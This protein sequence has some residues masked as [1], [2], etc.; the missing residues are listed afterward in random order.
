MIRKLESSSK[1]IFT[2]DLTTA[3]RIKLELSDALSEL[4]NINV[5]RV[6]R[7][8]N[9]TE[10]SLKDFSVYYRSYLSFSLKCNLKL[11]S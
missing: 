5:I 3:L 10:I 4:E 11:T 2:L 8:S 7:I 9:F 6:D 1:R